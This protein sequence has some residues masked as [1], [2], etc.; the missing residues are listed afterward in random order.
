M[1]DRITRA[2]MYS[3]WLRDDTDGLMFQLRGPSSSD[4]IKV[5]REARA[6]IKAALELVEHRLANME[7]V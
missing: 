3:A 2:K 5:L 1:S 7:T 6:N 4:E